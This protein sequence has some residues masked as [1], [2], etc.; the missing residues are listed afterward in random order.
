MLTIFWPCKYHSKL[1]QAVNYVYFPFLHNYC[2]FPEANICLVYGLFAP[3]LCFYSWCS[4]NSPPVISSSSPDIQV[5]LIFYKVSSSHRKLSQ[6]LWPVLSAC[7]A[8]VILG[9]SS[10]VS[11][12][13]L[14]APLLCHGTCD[15]CFLFLVLL[16]C[17]GGILPSAA[18]WGSVSRRLT[19]GVLT[20]SALS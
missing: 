6:S 3:F 15:L 11:P 1:N 10:A 20:L 16:P 4:P 18:S 5:L 13:L 7:R 9:S 17:L 14:R 12:G 2:V 19:F 8:A